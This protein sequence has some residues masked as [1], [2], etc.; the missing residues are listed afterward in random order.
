MALWGTSGFLLVPARFLRNLEG[1]PTG[2]VAIAVSLT[3]LQFGNGLAVGL[4]EAV[5][6]ALATSLRVGVAAMLLFPAVFLARRSSAVPG[7]RIII[8]GLVLGLMQLCFYQA[9]SL[10]PLSLA[11]SIEFVV[12]LVLG[13]LRSK[14]WAIRGPVCG[15]V[16]GLFLIADYGGRTD[17][18]GVLWALTTGVLLSIYIRVGT[19]MPAE[20]HPLAVLSKALRVAFPV[21]LVGQL[22]APSP[23]V[24]VTVA[25][26]AQALTVALLTMVV[27]FTLELYAM[28]RLRALPFALVSAMDP[29]LASTV[30]VLGLHQYLDGRQISGVSTPTP[31][32]NT[33]PRGIHW[34]PW[35]H[36][37]WACEHRRIRGINPN[38]GVARHVRS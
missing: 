21:V 32:P 33:P 28:K 23:P 31:R 24:T 4:I 8:Y 29:V 16:A 22:L 26:A 13:C 20:A 17:V 6:P 18:T 14:S 30:G 11:V 34:R 25:M 3:A 9:V 36:C 7:R 37:Y 1:A 27:P 2:V 12:P 38:H 10:L 19:T 15:A 35:G 5:G